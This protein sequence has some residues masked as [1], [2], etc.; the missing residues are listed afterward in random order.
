MKILVYIFL[1]TFLMVNTA[2]SQEE[3]LYTPA[4]QMEEPGETLFTPVEVEVENT[5]LSCK[6]TRKPRGNSMQ[7]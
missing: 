7:S 5:V 2:Y 6:R 1:I 3:I 4:T